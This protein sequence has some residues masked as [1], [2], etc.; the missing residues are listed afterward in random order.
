MSKYRRWEPHR[1]P[2]PYQQAAFDEYVNEHLRYF[3][4]GKFK[5]GDKTPPLAGVV[6]IWTE[7]E[8]EN[9]VL[10]GQPDS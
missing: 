1:Q 8:D 4:E 9:T 5:L 3:G 2:L 6:W 10:G 7:V